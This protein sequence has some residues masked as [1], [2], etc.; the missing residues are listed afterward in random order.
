METVLAHLRNLIRLSLNPFP[1]IA[2]FGTIFFFLRR[3]YSLADPD[4][5]GWWISK[6]TSLVSFLSLTHLWSVWGD[7]V[8][9]DAT[10]C[11]PRSIP[12]I[13]K[14]VWGISLSFSICLSMKSYFV[15]TGLPVDL[16]NSYGLY[17]NTCKG[18]CIPSWPRTQ[19]SDELI[20]RISLTGW[21][22]HS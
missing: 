7:T 5:S 14:S 1:L 16:I 4:N 2:A 12:S 13:Q 11:S 18:D 3:R 17:T 21:L 20:V 9:L 19:L 15:L 22:F 10:H 6:L 8:K